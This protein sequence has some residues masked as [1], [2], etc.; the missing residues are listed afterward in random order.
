M[1]V[2]RSTVVVHSE[3]MSTYHRRSSPHTRRARRRRATSPPQAPPEGRGSGVS[4]ASH[5]TTMHAHHHGIKAHAARAPRAPAAPVNSAHSLS[6]SQRRSRR[7]T[8]AQPRKLLPVGGRGGGSYAVG[9]S[10]S[11]PRAISHAHG[12]PRAL[13]L[14]NRARACALYVLYVRAVTGPPTAVAGYASGGRRHD[15][16]YGARSRGQRAERPTI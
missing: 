1:C 9:L 4:P 6:H 2:L 12:T 14:S 3:E 13:T 16:Q 7:R 10:R 15:A 5:H 11:G 8:A